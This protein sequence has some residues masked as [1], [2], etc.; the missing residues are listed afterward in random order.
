[1]SIFVL[2]FTFKTLCNV[3][4]QMWILKV[5]PRLLTNKIILI[6]GDEGEGGGRGPYS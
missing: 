4:T 1:M 2:N 3:K 5:K 6:L